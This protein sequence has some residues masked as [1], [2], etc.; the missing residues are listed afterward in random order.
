MF[1]KHNRALRL[2]NHISASLTRR[3]LQILDSGCACPA[4]AASNHQQSF[5]TAIDQYY[6]HT[7]T[8]CVPDKQLTVFLDLRIEPASDCSYQSSEHLLA[9]RIQ[10]YPR[11]DPPDR[12]VVTTNH[13]IACANTSITL[14][15]ITVPSSLFHRHK[16]LKDPPSQPVDERSR[17][18]PL[19]LP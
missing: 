3:L 16:L 1:S 12:A 9:P 5:P 11:Y 15:P 13:Q 2:T 19:L 18:P 4:P 10:S 17:H 14:A 6:I 7:A 8:K